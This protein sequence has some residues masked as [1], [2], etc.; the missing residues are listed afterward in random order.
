LRMARLDLV[1]DVG[2]DLDGAAEVVAPALLLDHRAVDL[3]R[4]DVVVPVMRAPVKR[5]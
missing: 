2:N 3:A 1:G 5:S 4:G